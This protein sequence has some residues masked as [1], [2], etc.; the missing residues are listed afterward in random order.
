MKL[1]VTYQPR[2]AVLAPDEARAKLLL[3]LRFDERG[4]RIRSRRLRL[5]EVPI[6]DARVILPPPAGLPRAVSG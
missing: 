1:Y 3:C 2:G 5:I 6:H 4:I